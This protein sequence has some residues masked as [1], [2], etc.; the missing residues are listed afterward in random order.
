MNS[1]KVSVKKRP[2]FKEEAPEFSVNGENTVS[3]LDMDDLKGHRSSAVNIFDD[4]LARP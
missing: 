4:R 3:V 2:V 1:F